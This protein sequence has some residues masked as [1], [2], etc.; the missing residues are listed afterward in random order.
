MMMKDNDFLPNRLDSKCF[1]C[2]PAN[3]SG[4]QMKFRADEE[5]VTS[6]LIVPVSLCGWNKLVHGGV[7]S[8]ILDEVMSWA[9]MFFVK[10]M[11]MT[12]S[13]KIDFIKPIQIDSSIHAEGKVL[14]IIN[15]HEVRMEGKIFNNKGML[16]A[17]SEAMFATFSPKIAKRLGITENDFSYWP[18]N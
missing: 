17:H 15:K 16:C 11:V 6:D 18:A 13:M 3:S 8:T 5:T 10:S 9:A 4:L 14:E 2:G 7:I 12:K 1:G